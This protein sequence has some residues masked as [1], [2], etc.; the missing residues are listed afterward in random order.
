MVAMCLFTM[1][2]RLCTH[3][4]NDS[5][6]ERSDS[7]LH[8]EMVAGLEVEQAEQKMDTSGPTTTPSETTTTPSAAGEPSIAVGNFMWLTDVFK[9]FK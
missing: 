4:D 3:A 1:C 8:G 2:F 7:G 5:V 9:S 6:S